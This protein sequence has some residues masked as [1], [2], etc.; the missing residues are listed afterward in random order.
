[1]A[2]VYAKGV[3]S[4]EKPSSSTGQKRGL[5]Y[6][7]IACLRELS[8]DHDRVHDKGAVIL[9]VPRLLLARFS[10]VAAAIFA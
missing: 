7:Q 10:A 8:A 6:T 3:C 4:S 1:M 2:K 5:V 9:S